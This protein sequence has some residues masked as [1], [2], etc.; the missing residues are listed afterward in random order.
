[1]NFPYEVDWLAVAWG[2]AFIVFALW[3]LWR[4]RRE[5]RRP[6]IIRHIAFMAL[7][8]VGCLCLL[9]GGW[10][11]NLMFGRVIYKGQPEETWTVLIR[12][13]EVIL[14]FAVAAVS[15]GKNRVQVF[16]RYLNLCNRKR[17]GASE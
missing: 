5:L 16:R 4:N 17:P 11:A 10:L 7:V 14:F 2:L 9:Y 1:M 3:F 12:L 13:G 15:L 6:E 8:Y